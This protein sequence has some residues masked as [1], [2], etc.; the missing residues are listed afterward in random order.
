MQHTWKG[1]KFI[2]IYN[3][4]DNKESGDRG[5]DLIELAQNIVMGD[6]CGHGSKF[7]SP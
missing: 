3:E 1:K 4:I 6:H 2:Q 5:M 7:W